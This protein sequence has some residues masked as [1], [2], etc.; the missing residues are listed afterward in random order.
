WIWALATL[1]KTGLLA[2]VGG[3]EGLSEVFGFVPSATGLD[4]YIHIVQEKF[5]LRQ[6]IAACEKAAQQCRDKVADPGLIIKETQ[7]LIDE[8]LQ[9]LN[10]AAHKTYFE[11]LT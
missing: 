7:T 9:G 1:E 8:A 2:E 10:G 4:H 6:V 5:A 11:V 3:K